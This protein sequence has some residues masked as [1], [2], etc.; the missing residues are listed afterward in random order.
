MYRVILSRRAGK[1]LEK[2]RQAGLSPKAKEIS[3]IVAINPYQ[4]P[5][6][7]EKLI[8]DLHGY[9]SRR[10]NG[11]H[12]YVYK[13]KPNDKLIKDKDGNIYQGIVHV[14]KMWTHYE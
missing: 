5:P 6:P 14:L 2:L 12:R 11:Q 7:Y 13:V 4:N 1:D 8:G 10:I 9:L 3:D